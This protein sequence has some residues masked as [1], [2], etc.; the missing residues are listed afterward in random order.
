MSLDW[1][2][3]NAA[4]WAAVLLAFNEFHIS[5]STLAIQ[6]I[7]YFLFV[8]AA[9]YAFSRFLKTLRSRYL[10]W[11]TGWLGVA[12]LCYEI[13][14]LFVPV[15]ILTMLVLPAYRVWFRR[16]EP[17]LAGLVFILV[18]LPDLAAN[19]ITPGTT[20]AT[21]GDHFSRI[22]GIGFTAHYLNFFLRDGVRAFYN[23][24]GRE[25]WD[26]AVG[27]PT[28]NLV[29]GVILLGGVI[30]ETLRWRR[31]EPIVKFLILSFWLVLGFF[32]LIR[33]GA[34]RNRLDPVLWLWVDVTLLP[35]CLILGRLLADLRGR[36][37]V[38]AATAI[39]VAIFI[40]LTAVGVGHLGLPSVEVGFNPEFIWPPDGR[41]VAVHSKFTFCKICDS[42]RKI[43]LAGIVT[44]DQRDSVTATDTPSEL[45]DAA[46]CNGDCI[47]DL[48]ATL[49]AGALVR[50][51][52]IIFRL[53]DRSG[54]VQ[55][56]T[57]LVHVCC[58]A[59][60]SLYVFP[61]KFWSQ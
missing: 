24:N 54:R 30:I 42:S 55:S 15:I 11:A 3:V 49:S 52:E 1:V 27:Y 53:T 51:Y 7:F 13:S 56:L 33:P 12:F 20:L 61:V 35:A 16:R 26:K 43:E 48:P 44:A 45:V 9:L 29:F 28:M 14:V 47:I 60:T 23:L 10:Y 37:L 58:Y 40:S 41:I 6:H 8:M 38:P 4:R 31:Q 57:D 2:G 21:Y 39:A 59:N 25:L 22:G 17:Y 18:T 46:F 50:D 5:M 34:T 32:V 19:F 36:W